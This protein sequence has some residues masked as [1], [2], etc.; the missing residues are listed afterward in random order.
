[1]SVGQ[2]PSTDIV[3]VACVVEASLL[4]A[5]EWTRILIE[6]IYPLLKR[7][8]ELHPSHQVIGVLR[9]IQLLTVCLQFR[10]AFVAYG[11]ADTRPQPLLSKRFFAP[12]SLVTRELRDE[13]SKLGIGQT[14]SGSG[15][16]LSAL[17]GLVAAIEVRQ[18]FCFACAPDYPCR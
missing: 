18:P 4:I 14:N 11:A 13:P 15:R 6:Y 8:N 17:E 2:E 16:G 5:S 7:L 10:L 9:A 12:L 1:M 3:A